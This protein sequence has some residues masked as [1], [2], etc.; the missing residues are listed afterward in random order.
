MT[1]ICKGEE[2]ISLRHISIQDII[3]FNK[4]LNEIEINL[5]NIK[6]FNIKFKYDIDANDTGSGTLE[7]K[8][9][10][11]DG[12]VHTFQNNFYDIFNILRF[13]DGNKYIMTQIVE[14]LIDL[15]NLD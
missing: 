12:V 2:I 10:K 4:R 3:D 11:S 1:I 14:T 15:D 8:Y 6:K 5:Y 13:K 9:S 7:Y